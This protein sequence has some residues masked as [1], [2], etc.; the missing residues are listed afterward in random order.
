MRQAA[1]LPMPEGATPG[2]VTSSASCAIG[3]D[4]DAEA[5]TLKQ[6]DGS[7]LAAVLRRMLP[8]LIVALIG[9]IF[10]SL[11]GGPQ[12]AL[13]ELAERRDQLLGLVAR[14]RIVAP[15]VFVVVYA[16]LITLMWVPAIVCTVSAAFLFGL[17]L[18]VGCS[19]VGATLGAVNV[20]LLARHGFAGLTRLAGPYVQRFEAGFRSDALSYLLVL[21][22]I[23][24]LPFVVVNVL[25]GILG[26][27]LRAYMVATI[28]GILPS[29]FIY[30]GLGI[31]L[32]EMTVQGVEIDGGTLLRPGLLLPV[33]GLAVLC[34]TPVLWRHWRARHKADLDGV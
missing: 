23:P 32:R 22:L 2:I 15:L 27:R 33:L 1:G 16:L 25:P 30:A 17:W 29:T 7:R 31:G 21:R 4:M 14:H 24:L 19:L 18:G 3:S 13:A 8:F 34:L 6:Q 5:A 11:A 20:F 10:V 28:L 12:Q 26:V 9:A